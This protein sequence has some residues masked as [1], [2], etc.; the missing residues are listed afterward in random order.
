[1]RVPR[2]RRRRRNVFLRAIVGLTVT[3]TLLVALVAGTI[4]MATVTGVGSERLRLEAQS[5]LSAFAGVPIGIEA[6]ATRVSMDGAGVVA[7]EVPE[8]SLS[9]AGAQ[10]TKVG[11]LRFGVDP[12][13]LLSGRVTLESF[14]L[15]DARVAMTALPR[16]GNGDWLAGLTDARGLVDPDRVVEAAFAALDRGFSA[17]ENRSTRLIS[18]SNITV[19][20]GEGRFRSLHVR[21]ARLEM[22][23]TGEM[24]ISAA[25]AIDGR[26]LSASGTARRSGGAGSALEFSISTQ[27]D[28][29]TTETASLDARGGEDDGETRLSGAVAL[30][31]SG[32]R[33]QADGRDRLRV[34]VS[35]SN[36]A[37][38]I[39]ERPT[40]G[41]DV[42]LAATLAK[43]TGKIEIDRLAIVSGRSRFAFHGAIAPGL[44]SDRDASPAYRYELVSDGSTA[45]ASEALEPAI[46]FLA[47]V[48]GSYRPDERLLTAS[49]IGVRTG[50][51]E[52]FARATVQ[53]FEGLAPAIAFAMEVPRMPVAHA[54]QLWPIEAARGARAWVL[55]H[56]FGGTIRDSELRFRVEGGRLGNGIP[57]SR[58]EVSGR[59]QVD[60]TRFDI[61]GELPPVR[62]AD[63]V[64]EFHGP[65]VD[66]ALSTGV[67]YM[68]TGRTVEASNGTFTIRNVESQPFIGVMD[69][70]VKGDAPS[71]VEFASY[72]PIDA[73]RHLKF[74]PEDFSGEVS[75][76]VKADIPLRAGFPIEQ[77]KWQ[78]ALDYSGLALARE[79]EGQQVTDAR[80]TIHVDPDR[81]VIKAS[82]RLNG[83]PAEI[84]MTEPLHEGGPTRVRDIV[85]KLDDAGRKRMAPGLEG[86]VSG[87]MDVSV[88]IE[89]SGAQRMNIDLTRARVGI[90]WIGWSKGPGIAAT[91]SFVLRQEGDVARLSGF[92]LTGPSFGIAGDVTLDKGSLSEARFSKVALNRED[93]VA[94]T[95]RRAGRRYAIDVSGAAFDA[96]STI[97]LYLADTE[98]AERTVEPVPVTLNARVGR[99]TGFGGETLSDLSLTVAGAG[100]DVGTLDLSAK[101]RSGAG[102]KIVNGTDGGG[103]SVAVQSS[104]AGAIL[105]FLNIYEYMQGGAINLALA[106]TGRGPLRGQID[107]RNFSIVNEPKLRS[108]VATAPAEGDGR[109][110][111]QAVRRDIDVS[112]AD[113]ERGFAL[114]EKGDRYLSIDRGVLRGPAI[115]ATFQGSLYDRRGEMAITGTFMPAYGV[116]RLFAEIPLFGQ[117]LG[118]GRDRGLIG[119]TFKLAGDVKEPQLQVNPIS[120]IAPGIFRSIF[121]FN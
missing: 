101:A 6:G 14:G 38:S 71:V 78:V 47:R 96:R 16:T 31:L 44:G 49:E 73:M 51:G 95:I 67:V 45:A 33:A 114:V 90:P 116:N 87:P 79:I 97:R 69:V 93:D 64:V 61:T 30:S 84:G 5:A 37:L 121:E 98:V 24:E 15:A 111:N 50:P 52:L 8:I 22:G 53:F 75:G 89:P 12:W 86:I 11:A 27:F 66:I 99:V 42:D 74:L 46:N 43:G 102:V 20:L 82:A 39:P 21:E 1:M 10:F 68:P 18:L 35:A 88:V 26:P 60:D 19:D 57:L 41:G 59:F 108:L 85:L 115:G 104:D 28:L 118:N 103:R 23:E 40:M 3:L 48:A 105:R 63:G 56:I 109:S 120:A 4:Y 70:N 100:T 17:F 2:R 9:A 117:L 110:L 34:T 113:F 32:M 112:K 77:L 13:T 58:E 92:S 25:L 106:S 107:A 7:L 119:I 36:V 55:S 80:G 72:K 54:K 94:V 81:A 76:N 91:A 62:D 65:D 29:G 83:V